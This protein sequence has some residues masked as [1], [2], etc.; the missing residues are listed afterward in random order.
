MLL[1]LIHYYDTN[2]NIIYYRKY[3]ILNNIYYYYTLSDVN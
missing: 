2:A 1:N 3:Q